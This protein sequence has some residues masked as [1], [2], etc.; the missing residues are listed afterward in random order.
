[1]KKGI[2][3]GIIFD[4]KTLLL[5]N[6]L[7]LLIILILIIVIL[8][9]TS[10]DDSF[11]KITRDQNNVFKLTSPILDC[12]NVS[13]NDSSVISLYKVNQKVESLKDKYGVEDISLYFRDLNNGPWVGISEEKIFS[14]A[15]LLK[16]PIIMALFKY[17]ET[18]PD[19]LNKEII[20]KESDILADSNQNIVFPDVLKKDTKYTLL[21]VAESMIKKSDNAGVGIILNNIP[22]NY[23]DGVFRSIGVPYKDLNTEVSLRVKDY[24]AFFRVLFNA[25]YLDREMSEKTLE[26]LSESEYKNG[27]VAG[28]PE[29]ITVAH[30]FGERVSDNIYQLHDCGIIY[31]PQNPYLLCVM[32]RG[33][34]FKNQ[35]DF[36]KDISNY[37]YTE[38][39]KNKKS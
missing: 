1:M 11:S 23:V 34:S 33:N 22:K 39:D 26:I 28:V 10:Q 8:F 38:I 35:E 15:S 4:K 37:I 21:Q 24:A 19:I 13:Q 18:N 31:Y 3:W 20:T 7:F 12:E 14:P 17:A 30:K 36:I 27:L 9:K 29:D 2:F 5:I 16:T 6:F 32:T 25:S